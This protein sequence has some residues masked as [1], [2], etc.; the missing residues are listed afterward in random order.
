MINYVV[1]IWNSTTS[2]FEEY[3]VRVCTN[4]TNNTW[5]YAK[6]YIYNGTSWDVIGAAH[7]LYIPF[8]TSDDKEF[9]TLQGKNLVVRSH[10]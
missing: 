2:Q 5:V 9:L 6:P 3:D 10:D 7:S 4:K 8:Y 1:G